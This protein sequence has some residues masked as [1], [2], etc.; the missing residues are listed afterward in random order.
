MKQSMLP[1][2]LVRTILLSWKN[3][4]IVT[5]RQTPASIVGVFLFVCVLLGLTW[6]IAQG[7]A[8]YIGGAEL[9]GATEMLLRNIG[10]L[11]TGGAILLTIILH[12]LT[13]KSVPAT[14]LQH[15]PFTR[16]HWKSALT[17][18]L[19]T[20]ALA[21]LG[22]FQGPVVVIILRESVTSWSGGGLL[23]A[24]A[25]VNMIAGILIGNCLF[26]CLESVIQ[27][28]VKV[29]E[30]MRQAA[31]YMTFIATVIVLLVAYVKF[32]LL[33]PDSFVARILPGA[34]LLHAYKGLG[35]SFVYG[36]LW[37]GV[38]LAF[39]GVLYLAQGFLF[40]HAMH[41]WPVSEKSEA[42]WTRAIRV[43]QTSSLTALMAVSVK[44]LLRDRETIMMVVSTQA[45]PI[46]AALL[47]RL[48]RVEQMTEMFTGL[49]WVLLPLSVA[50]F[51]IVARNR[52]SATRDRLYNKPV[53]AHRLIT[54]QMLAVFTLG[55]LCALFG[56]LVCT[57]LVGLS[58]TAATVVQFLRF[59][60]LG[61]AVAYVI[62]NLLSSDRRKLGYG[63]VPFSVYVFASLPLISLDQW[64]RAQG[65]LL[66]VGTPILL[67]IVLFELCVLAEEKSV[68]A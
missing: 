25:F 54:A 23:L 51:G 2:L 39:V 13:V 58:L 24:V 42:G 32:V 27:R 26:V 49:S 11:M 16:R 21:A 53:I 48:F 28:F 6:K 41:Q 50:G 57:W 38:S 4:A 44:T 20:I 67:V 40:R 7:L 47:I 35:I 31:L 17:L 8:Q 5:L 62:G 65:V 33:T 10:P 66:Q 43:P 34:T 9:S 18:I 52:L 1:Q 29:S 46:I 14:G 22:L 15:L 3:K 64:L 60:L 37:L 36:L 56:F 45:I 61:L 63:L 30:D 19:S 55:G 59:A 68:G 12:L